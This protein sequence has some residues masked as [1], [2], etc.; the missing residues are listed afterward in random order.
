MYNPMDLTGRRILVTGASSGIGR[1][2]AVELSRLGATV[3]LVARDEA[4]LN[5]TLSQMQSGQH[6]TIRCD[7]ANLENIEPIFARACEG[8]SKLD[9]LVHAAGVSATVP[10]QMTTV[11]LI[12]EMTAL[13]Y[14]SFLMLARGFSKKKYSNGGS[15]VG[16]SSVASVAGQPGMSV[17]C[18]TKGALDSAVRALARELAGRH[19]RVNS[20]QPSYV[21]TKMHAEAVES[22]PDE[23]YQKILAQHPMGLGEPEDVAH[24]VSFLLSDA[25]RFITGITLAVDGGYLA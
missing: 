4:R 3:I 14:G 10:L 12:Q 20:V 5:E 25:A 8:A 6:L 13:N 1:A 18:G 17:Y 9:G 11:K 23:S 24:A 19:I 15:I 21:R 7:L 2:C 16:L 22:L